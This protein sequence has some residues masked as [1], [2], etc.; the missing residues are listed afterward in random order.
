M[1]PTNQPAPGIFED[2]SQDHFMATLG[3]TVDIFHDLFVERDPRF[4]DQLSEI[5]KLVHQK[6]LPDTKP[7][8]L[9]T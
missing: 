7:H 5:V 9:Y 1:K 8:V 6:R 3:K 4:L 2:L